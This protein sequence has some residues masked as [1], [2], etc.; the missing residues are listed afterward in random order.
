MTKRGRAKDTKWPVTTA[1]ATIYERRHT[2]VDGDR[3]GG[4]SDVGMGD[5]LVKKS[6]IDSVVGSNSVDVGSSSA[7]PPPPSYTI[8]CSHSRGRCVSNEKL[9][10]RSVIPRKVT[11]LGSSFDVNLPAKIY[12]TPGKG[13]VVVAGTESPCNRNWKEAY[14]AARGLLVYVQR[15]PPDSFSTA[16]RLGS[17]GGASA[18]LH[19]PKQLMDRSIAACERAY[20]F[21]SE[22]SVRFFILPSY[23]GR[24]PEQNNFAAK[25][26]VEKE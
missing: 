8:Q 21:D 20:G 16:F 9:K 2:G 12:H 4:G 25:A 18:A 11:V 7:P 24:E 15:F 5:S 1:R 23:D 3:D 6:R 13:D 22:R 19:Y 10:A 17:D 14:A 26:R